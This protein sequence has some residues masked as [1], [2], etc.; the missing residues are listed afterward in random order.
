MTLASIVIL[1]DMSVPLLPFVLRKVNNRLCHPLATMAISVSAHVIHNR[2]PLCPVLLRMSQIGHRSLSQLVI[3]VYQPHPTRFCHR[4]EMRPAMVD[5]FDQFLIFVSRRRVVVEINYRAIK[6]RGI[7]SYGGREIDYDVGVAKA[8]YPCSYLSFI[9]TASRQS[10][11]SLCGFLHHY[12]RRERT[13]KID[14][15]L[16]V[17]DGMCAAHN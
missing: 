8:V 11:A 6:Y 2:S 7:D 10:S 1:L 5:L 12:A 9:L 3:I 13:K 16:I 15:L 4:L 14:H 17:I